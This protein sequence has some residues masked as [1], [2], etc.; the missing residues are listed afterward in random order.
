LLLSFSFVPH[1]G[2][3]P[4]SRRHTSWIIRVFCVQ[5]FDWYSIRE[6]VSNS[7]FIFRAISLTSVG[8][9]PWFLHFLP[10]L[11]MA[12]SYQTVSN[13]WLWK[14]WKRNDLYENFEKRGGGGNEIHAPCA[15]DVDLFLLHWEEVKKCIL[16]GFQD[17][18]AL[19]LQSPF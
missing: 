14:F 6:K 17:L 4:S 15:C 10:Y 13:E 11:H 18:K 5:F 7:I 8:K 2:G 12:L 9:P 3:H 16:H 1:M 19:F